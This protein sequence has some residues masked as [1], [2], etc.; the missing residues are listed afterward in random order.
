MNAMTE[1]KNLRLPLT[2][3]GIPVT[4]FRQIDV[5][6]DAE[7]KVLWTF[8]KP[9]GAPCFNLGLLNEI[10]RSDKRLEINRGQVEIDG[11]L[12]P[13]DF[14]VG[15]SRIPDVFSYGG[16]LALFR[17]LISSRD[18]EA[19]LHYARLCVDTLQHR[20]E[21][22]KTNVTTISLIQGE[23]LGGGFESALASHVLIAEEHARMGFPEILFNLFPGMGAYSLLSRR[24]GAR[25]AEEI[26]LSGKIYTAQ[27]MF[28]L[29]LVDLVV[30]TGQGEAAVTNYARQHG[31][32]LNGMRALFECRRHTQ[33]VSYDELIGITEVWVD[34]AL[35]L[36]DK[37]LKMMGRLVRSQLRQQEARDSG[38]ALEP[39]ELS[40]AHG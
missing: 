21:S 1:H 19:L 2:S 35:R 6:Y 17:Q 8:M 37:D 7:N 38:T 40:L 20:L 22:F 14:H 5:E 31:R 11:T 9:A 15:A 3:A 29:G 18:R 13:V 27:E 36:Q 30:P 23:A 32:H 33:P 10:R 34:A 12:Y 26:I 28:A 4:A 16:D 24:V 25:K 39:Q